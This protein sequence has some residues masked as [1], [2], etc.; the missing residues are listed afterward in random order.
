[1]DQNFIKVE[2]NLYAKESAFLQVIDDDLATSH[3]FSYP[4]KTSIS[5]LFLKVQIANSKEKVFTLD[6][7]LFIDPSHVSP[8]TVFGISY[9]FIYLF[10]YLIC[11]L[12]RWTLN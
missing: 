3:N 1:M 12:C 5:I 8:G 9:L 11:T 7:T 2:K 6:A 4:Y 10:L